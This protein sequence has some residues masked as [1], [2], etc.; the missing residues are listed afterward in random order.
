MHDGLCV[1]VTLF[2]FTGKYIRLCG[3]DWCA[4]S[5]FS[6]SHPPSVKVCV[7]EKRVLAGRCI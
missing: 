5:F 6:R 7:P 4:N 3:D 2:M 1:K